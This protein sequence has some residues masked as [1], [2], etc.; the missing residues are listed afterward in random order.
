[1]TD[2]M[3]LYDWI[4]GLYNTIGIP[5]DSGYMTAADIVVLLAFIYMIEV[6]LHIVSALFDICK[7]R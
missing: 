6:F 2:T 4:L 3:T 5:L 7:G 1:M